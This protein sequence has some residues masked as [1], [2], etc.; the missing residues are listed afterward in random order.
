[1]SRAPTP[2][3]G[4]TLV[5][6]LL[7]ASACNG[8]GD[9]N[10]LSSST[11]P[12]TVPA[13]STTAPATTSPPATDP[14]TTV[15]TDGSGPTTTE[16]PPTTATTTTPP[17]TVPTTG[18]PAFAVSQVV[19]GEGAYISLKNIGSGAGSTNGLWLCQF[20]SCWP[21]PAV[22]LEAGEVV[23]ISVGESLPE[24]LEVVEVIKAGA[25]LGTIRQANGEI[26]LYATGRFTDPEAILDYVEWGNAGHPRSVVAI[27]AGI[28]PTGG[29]RRGSRRGAGF[30]R[31]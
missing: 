5:A 19:F 25:T 7:V 13:S 21:L 11:T 16:T 30:A 3:A 20:P 23:A 29:V 18:E 27:A 22:D 1:M 2:A 9:G 14:A 12:G 4:A 31:R 8:A 24:L 28:W 26:G 10:P 6:L 15:T 17:P